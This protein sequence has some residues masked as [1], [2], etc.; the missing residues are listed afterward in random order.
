MSNLF[1]DIAQ[2]NETKHYHLSDPELV[3]TNFDDMGELYRSLVKEYGKCVS[4]QY[5]GD[6]VQIGW[7]FEKRVKYDDVRS[8][9]AFKHMTP[10]ERDK[11][12]FIMATWVAVHTEKPTKTIINH[13]AKF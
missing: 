11:C 12:S 13:Y 6:G 2:T 1:I 4:K 8:S 7:V 5:I 9:R 10:V 3:E